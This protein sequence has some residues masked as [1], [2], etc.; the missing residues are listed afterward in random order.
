MGGN[1]MLYLILHYTKRVYNSS[2]AKGNKIVVNYV[3]MEEEG[4]VTKLHVTL[5]DAQYSSV[6]I[7][8]LMR[9]RYLSLQFPLSCCCHLP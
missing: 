3:Q 5:C 1:M 6:L 9:L 4:D 8:L 7:L 2:L